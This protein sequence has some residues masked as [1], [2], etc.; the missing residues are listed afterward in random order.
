MKQ[1]KICTVVTGSTLP[2]FLENLKLCQEKSEIIELRVDHISNL[3]KSFVDEIR[4]K[5]I[6]P[7]IFTCRKKDEGG[8]FDGSEEIRLDIIKHAIDLEFDYVDIEFSTL[9]NNPIDKK[10]SQLIVSFHDFEKTPKYWELTKLVFNMKQTGADIVKI[11]TMVN[12][13]YD[14]QVLYR[15]LLSKK[16]EEKQI[17]IGMGELGRETRIIAPILGSYLTYAAINSNN[18]APGQTN[19]ERLVSIYK[20]LKDA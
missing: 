1:I 10:N 2:E 3:E 8:K 9:I 12:I 15:V 11:A 17:I 13:D 7:A 18:T 5:T 20:S 4:K 14:L 6:K 19:A 16:T